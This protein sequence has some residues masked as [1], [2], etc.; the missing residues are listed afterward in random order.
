MTTGTTSAPAAANLPPDSAADRK[1]CRCGVC[2]EANTLLRRWQRAAVVAAAAGGWAADRHR[3]NARRE[4]VQAATGRDDER[5]HVL[6]D[7]L[8]SQGFSDEVSLHAVWF[9]AVSANRHGTDRFDPVCGFAL[10]Q[11]FAVAGTGPAA[12]VEAHALPACGGS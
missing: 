11:L 9:S 4:R 12:V 7:A 6:F 1:V 3:E 8:I 2:R 5:Q 10:A